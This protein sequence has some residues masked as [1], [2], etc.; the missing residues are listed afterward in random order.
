M[1][2]KRYLMTHEHILKKLGH[3]TLS[4][5]LLVLEDV[6]DWDRDHEG[7][8]EKYYRMKE[9]FEKSREGNARNN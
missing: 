6:P 8:T 3:I 9:R 4:E 1:S 2:N 5:I 7:L